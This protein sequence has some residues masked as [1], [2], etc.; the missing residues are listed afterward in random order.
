M[1]KW[2]L[3]WKRNANIKIKHKI[4]F[5]VNIYSLLIF[6]FGGGVYKWVISLTF[7]LNDSHFQWTGR[8]QY[9]FIVNQESLIFQIS[10]D[11]KCCLFVEFDSYLLIEVFKF[12]CVGRG[13]V[14]YHCNQ[15]W[16][17]NMYVMMSSFI[18][19]I[20][21]KKNQN[22]KKIFLLCILWRQQMKVTSPF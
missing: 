20:F 2:H 9:R 1:E 17:L 14:W 11:L 15:R 16:S 22:Q 4:I 10:I 12:R 19:I 6:F 18:K 8:S 3:P 21:F 7:L 13:W 5:T